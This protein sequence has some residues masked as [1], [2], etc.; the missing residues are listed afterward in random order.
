MQLIDFSTFG[1]PARARANFVLSL[2]L[3]ALA[4]GLV[5]AGHP[6]LGG[7]LVAVIVA[8]WR[9]SGK[10]VPVSALGPFSA[11]IGKTPPPASSSA[12]TL[13]D[14]PLGMGPP[15]AA[16]VIGFLFAFASGCATAAIDKAR[17]EYAR[18]LKAQTAIQSRYKLQQKEFQR[19]NIE[20]IGAHS[21]AAA[22][23]QAEWIVKK[24]PVEDQIRR[25]QGILDEASDFLL[26]S[27]D[28]RGL[29][30]VANASAC[31]SAEKDMIGKLFDGGL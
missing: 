24:S 31:V 29:A 18:T 14:V 25:C 23:W 17:L 13:K 28:K 22:A 15:G 19:K 4:L 16:M 5:I 20:R 21:A 10:G 12:T 6:P 26:L 3:G 30:T 1:D 9:P 8:L 7:A 11:A 2:L 27:D